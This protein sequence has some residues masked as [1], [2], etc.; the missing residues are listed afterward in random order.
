MSDSSLTLLDVKLRQAP[1]EIR[2][3]SW[4]GLSLFPA[5]RSRGAFRPMR[6][7]A[8]LYWVM[9]FVL[10]LTYAGCTMMGEHYYAWGMIGSNSIIQSVDYLRKA[11]TLSPFDPQNRGAAARMLSIFAM[12]SEDRQWLEAARAEC[13]VELQT[14]YSMADILLKLYV[15]D[16]KLN[17][18]QEAQVVFDQ[19]KRVDPKSPLIALVENSTNK[20]VMPLPANP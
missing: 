10:G 12:K 13:I 3:L 7:L 6:L 4:L 8:R 5:W 9:L 11:G 19:F 2:F 17:L 14:D 1:W 20:P 18:T 16:L 15:I